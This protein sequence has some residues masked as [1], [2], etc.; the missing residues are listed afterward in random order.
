M[1][2]VDCHG[3]PYR[4]CRL[5]RVTKVA[6]FSS[7]FARLGNDEVP[8]IRVGM[9]ERSDWSSETMLF[10]SYHSPARPAGSPRAYGLV[11]LSRRW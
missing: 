4:I 10:Q 9:I 8:S 7:I 2:L 5:A 11:Q 6:R 1:R 3:Q